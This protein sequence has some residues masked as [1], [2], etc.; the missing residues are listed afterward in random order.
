VANQAREVWGAFYSPPRESARWGVRDPEISRSGAGHVRQTSLNPGR[1][2]GQVRFW[3]LT[4][5]KTERPVMSGYYFYNLVFVLD[6]SGWDLVAEELELGRTCPARIRSK[7]WICPV[8]PG[9][10]VCG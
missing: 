1:G 9:T 3:V 10:L 7:T 6:K 2:I 8:F 5:D 4:R